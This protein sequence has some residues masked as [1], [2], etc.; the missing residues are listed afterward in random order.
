MLNPQAGDRCTEG[1][2]ALRRFWWSVL[3]YDE[4]FQTMRTAMAGCET[5]EGGVPAFL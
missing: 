4:L 2:V 5:I 1:F 3:L